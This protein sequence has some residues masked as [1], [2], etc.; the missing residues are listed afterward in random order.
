MRNLMLAAAVAFTA[1]AFAAPSHAASEEKEH[2]PPECFDK[3]LIG[4]DSYGKLVIKYVRVC[5]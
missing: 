1:I 4:Y 3:K 2:Q 5:R